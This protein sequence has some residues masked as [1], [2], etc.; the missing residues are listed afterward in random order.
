MAKRMKEKNERNSSKLIF[1]IFIV[2]VFL[3]LLG[4]VF[5]LSPNYIR[6]DYDGKTKVLINNNNVT[7]KMKNDVY[8]DENNNVFLSLAD[9]RNYF[10]KYIEYDK[11]NGS[12]V[13]TSEINIAKMSTKD[14]KITIIIDKTP[15]IINL[16]FL[17][18]Y[19]TPFHIMYN[20][21]ILKLS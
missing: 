9:V 5:Y 1:N 3:A 18:I 16:V 17:S 21:S 11:E 15:I 6:E 12:I 2:L 10:D 19:T 8:I 20:L 13:T 14:N 4:G 7:L